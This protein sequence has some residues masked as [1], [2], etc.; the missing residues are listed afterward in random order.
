MQPRNK[1]F[2]SKLKKK[3]SFLIE[4]ELLLLVFE[5]LIFSI[6]FIITEIVI[7]FYVK[8]KK[9]CKVPDKCLPI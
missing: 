8:Q 3:F 4:N 6:T 2:R 5:L 7:D 9:T 1:S